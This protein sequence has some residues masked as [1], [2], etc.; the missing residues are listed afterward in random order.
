MCNQ[1]VKNIGGVIDL[2]SE[3]EQGSTFIIKLPYIQKS[4]IQSFDLE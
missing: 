4:G 3:L 1:I 2:K